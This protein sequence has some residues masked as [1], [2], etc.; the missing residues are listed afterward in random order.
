[1]KRVTPKKHLGQHFLKDKNIARKIVDS[2][3]TNNENLII[4]I[5]PGTGVLTD[6]LIDKPYFEAYDVDK[7]SVEFLK[8]K[9]GEN[10]NKIYLKDFL[11]ENLEEK[12]TVVNVIGNFPYNI[13]SQIFFHIYDNRNIVEQVVCMIQKEVAERIASK[14][15]NKTYGILSVLLK[16]FYE[17]EYL[18]T[19]KPGVFIPPPKVNSAVIRL[20]RN[21]TKKLA[22]NE[23]LFKK[24]V[25][26]GFNQRRKTLRNS[27]KTLA[28]PEGLKNHEYLN[29]RAEQL[30][31][32]QFVEL[33]KM[34]EEHAGD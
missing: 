4:E 14:E 12:N 25:K 16:A 26:A 31:V 5:G 19:V 7:E 9:Y 34:I 30:S 13:S 28:L 32:D 22:C 29:K 17:I 3:N 27:L 2:L 10:R 8:E 24:V 6:L 11:T 21:K 15:G 23:I 1:M 33:T 20:S 18:I